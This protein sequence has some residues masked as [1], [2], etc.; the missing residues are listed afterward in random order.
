MARSASEAAFGEVD[1]RDPPWLATIAR[2]W[3]RRTA[4]WSTSR[5]WGGSWGMSRRARERESSSRSCFFERTN[6]AIE[7][8]GICSMWIARSTSAAIHSASAVS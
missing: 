8:G 2:S 4:G 1:G 3:S 7:D 6:T 5:V